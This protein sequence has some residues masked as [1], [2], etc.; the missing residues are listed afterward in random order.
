MSEGGYGSPKKDKKGKKAGEGII[1]GSKDK[2]TSLLTDGFKEMY[3][4]KDKAA[5]DK[6]H[7]WDNLKPDS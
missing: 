7:T 5:P 3:G 6:G 2:A 1:V 4:F